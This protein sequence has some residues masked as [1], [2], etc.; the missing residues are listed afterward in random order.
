MFTHSNIKELPDDF[1]TSNVTDMQ[2]MF[3]FSRISKLPDNFDTSNVTN[4]KFMFKRSQV[5]SL[6][7]NFNTSN[8]T[9][10]EGMFASSK[11][12][13]LPSNFNTSNVTNMEGMFSVYN[14]YTDQWTA[15]DYNDGYGGGN[16]KEEDIPPKS[17]YADTC[18]IEYLPEGFDTSNVINMKWMFYKNRKITSLPNSFITSNVANMVSMFQDS[19]IQELPMFDTS[20]VDTMINMFRDTKDFN[21]DISGWD[22]SDQET[23]STYDGS[24]IPWEY[25]N[26][27]SS[28]INAH[29]P[30]KFREDN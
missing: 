19:I 12:K 23:I 29:I 14:Y 20:K 25:F 1:D 18:Q 21:Q 4:M 16:L 24:F 26:K 15:A 30:E 13:K 22:V 5:T 28:L 11:L 8:V 10:M 27:D 2:D 6:P 3:S 17:T 7:D 9:N